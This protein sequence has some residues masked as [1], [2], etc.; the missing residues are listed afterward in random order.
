[1]KAAARLAVCLSVSL[2]ALAALPL[3]AQPVADGVVNSGEYTYS[4]GDWRMAWDD[5]Y[6]YVAKTGIATGGLAVHLDID[7][8]STPTAGSSANG[9]LASAP[10]VYSPATEPYVANLPFRGDVRVVAGPGGEN[11]SIRDGNGGWTNGDQ[12]DLDTGYGNMTV[13]FSVRWDGLPGLTA[14]PASFNWVA[15]QVM[16][17]DTTSANTPMPDA[18]TT[19]SGRF[20]YFLH[21]PAT[22]SPTD[23]FTDRRSTWLVTYEAN[24]GANTLR[25]AIDNANND[26]ASTR[27][28]IA[29]DLTDATIYLATSLQL[30]TR[31]TTIDGSSQTGYNGTPLVT[32]HGA[33]VTPTVDGINLFNAANCEIRGF[34]FGNL[35]R[36]IIVGNGADYATIAANHIG[37]N[38]PNLTGIQIQGANYATVGGTTDADRNV[39]SGNTTGISIHTTLYTSVHKNYVGTD[40][41]GM[42]SVPNF[43]GITI[44]NNS[45]ATIG[46]I[47]TGNVISGNDNDGIN[48]SD[49]NDTVILANLI[50]VAADGTTALG[51]DGDGI[52]ATNM[53]TIGSLGAGNVIAN[54]G[55]TGVRAS[56][57]YTSIRYNS[58]FA[59]GSNLSMTNAQAAPTIQ[60]A[61]SG[62]ASNLGLK[63]T[64]NASNIH[65]TTQSF[66]LDLYRND[67]GPK[68]LVATRCSS[69]GEGYWD[70][71]S[72]FAPGD[73][74]IL[75]ATAYQNINCAN[76]GD[77]T[78]SM[79]TAFVVDN[80][81]PTSMTLSSNDAT[82]WSGES[83]TLTATITG[84]DGFHPPSGT[85]DFYQGGTLVCENVDVFG[86]QAQCA[87]TAAATGAQSFEAI[88]S[89]DAYNDGSSDTESVTVKLHVFTGTGNFTSTANWTDGALPASGEHFRI[90][91]TSTYDHFEFQPFGTMEVAAGGT[92]ILTD[93]SFTMLRVTSITGSGTINMTAGG[94]LQFSSSF[95]DTINFIR[96]TGT[97]AVTGTTTLPAREFHT[98]A[99]RGTITS[100]GP[101]TI[102][103]NLY[104]DAGASF[105][106]THTITMRG[107]QI[108]NDGTLQFAT[109]NIA[110]SV[111]TTVLDSF[112]ATTLDVDGTLSPLS[113]VVISGGTITGS[114]TVIVTSTTTP[115]SFRSQ[116]TATNRDL[117]SLTA[118][119][120]GNAAQSIDTIEFGNL[121]I[122]N[123]NG[124]SVT[125]SSLAQITG[126]L[127]LTNGVVETG[128]PYGDLRVHNTAPSS[129]V[130]TNGWVSGSG[131]TRRT[132]AGTNTYVFPVGFTNARAFAT[133]TFYDVAAPEYASVTAWTPAS[134]GGTG[135]GSGI[136]TARDANVFWRLSNSTAS[137][138]DITVDYAG[139]V[140]GAAVP[141]KFAFRSRHVIG[142]NN[143]WVHTASTASA[144][145]IT[146]LNV[147]RQN[148]FVIWITAGNQLADAT[149]SEITTASSHL[150]SNGTSTTTVNVQ[151]RDALNVNLSLGGD[152]VALQ[153]TLGSLGAV[154]DH[155]NGTYTATLT[156]GNTAGTATITGTANGVAITDN[157]VVTFGALGNPS[158]LVAAAV[159]TTAITLTWTAAPGASGYT[160]ERSS[161]GGAF[162][163]IGTAGANAF[164]DGGATATTSYLYRVRATNGPALSDYSNADLATT[165]IFTDPSLA[166]GTAIKATQF[167]ELRSAVNAVRALAGLSPFSFTN[168][169]TSG[170]TFRKSHVEEL[171]SNLASARAALGLSTLS[172]TDPT[173]TVGG[174]IKA[175]HVNELR[176]GVQ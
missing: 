149:K 152:T 142:D 83:Y 128:S 175:V 150:V 45:Y 13:E 51:N 64:V 94:S 67:N 132:A 102:H 29:F 69:P 66:A 167:N 115:N 74:L 163:Q 121:T 155:G 40:A 26:T 30:V 171:R 9:N 112:S 87:R 7:P 133:V 20:A 77:G 92:V 84:E 105:A 85:V 31:T 157:A 82:P 124:V 100:A 50:G 34:R 39:V 96:G 81:A 1:M 139:L 15:H 53:V 122:D 25:T 78:S 41:T 46:G 101:A 97:I 116:Y 137:K 48:V 148:T 21:V 120:Q 95:A 70:V 71:G 154:T 103:G 160:I 161:S 117:G 138:F 19:G 57:G 18:N 54:N 49:A 145:S 107:A 108:D 165:V 111:T 14:R 80:G 75:I 65:A 140:D 55:G 56:G 43:N 72:G 144:T 52:D 36:A 2:L 129:V 169:P 118:L 88:Y 86:G 136:N 106:P 59:N 16:G 126:V 98:V 91:G 109:L 90:D 93:A 8:R 38:A 164:T 10:I 42:T 131:F 146:A 11:L 173:L 162:V 99:I 27:R 47:G 22:G 168:P 23:P 151:L 89:G 32:I 134:V 172:F 79:S 24:S 125:A 35:A 119:F 141:A 76:L 60:Q 174:V 166:T 158:N 33:G 127:T 159:N 37:V 28:Y 113:A 73:S 130:T 62:D 123:L 63:L 5:T 12:N 61:S 143:T 68:T 110:S 114:G 170:G 176:G 44:E 104:V 4:S 6:L 3:T 135:N 58:I 147:L 17:T 153:T 156:A